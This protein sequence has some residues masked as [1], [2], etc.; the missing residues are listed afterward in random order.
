MDTTCGFD[1]LV[2]GDGKVAVIDYD[3]PSERTILPGGRLTLTEPDTGETISVTATGPALD[4]FDETPDGGFVLVRVGTGAWVIPTGD[5]L[6]WI[7]GCWTGTLVVQADGSTDGP[8]YDFSGARVV[9][10]CDDL[11]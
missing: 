2:E 9:D 5:G 7:R 3:G 6:L 1:V 8:S 4:T 11:G 10:L